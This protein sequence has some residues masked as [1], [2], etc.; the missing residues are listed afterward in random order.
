M[1]QIQEF[2]SKEI[3]TLSGYQVTVGMVIVALAVF[4]AYRKF[5]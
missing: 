4:Y 1:P 5:A 2:L 3:V